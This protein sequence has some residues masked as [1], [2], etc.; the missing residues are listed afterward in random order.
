MGIGTGVYPEQSG[1][2]ILSDVLSK[3]VEADKPMVIFDVGSNRGQFI[4]TLLKGIKSRPF[5]IHAFEPSKDAFSNLKKSH[6]HITGIIFNNFGLDNKVNDSQLYFDELSSLRASKYPLNLDHIGV[7]LTSSETVHFDTLDNYC[8]LNKIEHID[9]LKLDVEGNEINVL[10]GGSNV[11]QKGLIS[12][13]TFEFGGPDIDTRTSF[14]D[15]YYFLLKYNMKALYR[16][17]PTGFLFQISGYGEK[18]EMYFSTNYLVEMLQ[19][20]SG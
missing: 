6:R 19:T 13:I 12:H 20:K 10:K 17:T 16:I 5:Q 4:D 9:L 2:H 15:I 11:L 7:N 3:S 18:L 8:K 14:K 1:E